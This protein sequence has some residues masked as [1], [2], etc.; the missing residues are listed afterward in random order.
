LADA[1]SKEDQTLTK[2]TLRGAIIGAGYFAHNH[3]NAW[4]VAEGAEIIA[5]CDRDEDRASV[6]CAKFGIAGNFQD[7][8]KMFV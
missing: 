5:I 2:K 8:A 1:K 7:A 4:A 6:A 3:L